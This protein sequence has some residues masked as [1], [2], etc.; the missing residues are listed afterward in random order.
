MRLLF[1]LFLLVFSFETASAQ[2]VQPNSVWVN[3]GGS[4]LT[5]DTIAADGA[6][7]GTYVNKVAGFACQNQPMRLGGWKDGSLLN[8]AV[9]WKNASVDC[10]SITSWT[11][12][13]SAGKIYT[14]WDLIYTAASTGLPTHLTGSDIFSPQ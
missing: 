6:I 13:Y 12:Y 14:D 3:G 11:G 1:S 8:F 7:A 2:D 9:R 5:V 4:V 10:A